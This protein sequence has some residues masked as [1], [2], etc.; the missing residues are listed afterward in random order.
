MMA[1]PRL[2]IGAT[3]SGSG[4]TMITCGILQALVN[5]GLKVASFKCGPDYI[6]PMFHREVIGTHS[7]NLDT[8]FSG[9]NDTK[10]LLEKNATGMDISI[11]EGVMG[12]YDGVGGTTP[13]AGAYDL[14]RVTDTPAVLIVNTKGMS[15]SVLP[16]IKGFLEYKQD[17]KIKGV[18][19]NQ[20]SEMIYPLLKAQAEDELGIKVYGYVPRITDFTIESRHLGLVMPD[21]VE[22]LSVKLNGLAGILEKTLEIDE[23]IAL[24]NSA[25]E[26]T[27]KKPEIPVLEE[28]DGHPRVAVARDNAFCFYYQDN[29]DLLKEMGAQIV[30][31]SPINDKHLPENIDGLI[32]GGGYPELFGKELSE[33]KTMLEDMKRA[34]TGGLP[35]LA[36]CGGFMYLHNKMEAMDGNHYEMVGAIDGEVYR[37]PKLSRF[38]YINITAKHD[39]LLGK[40]GTI[41]RAHEFHYFDSTACGESFSAKKPLRKRGWDCVNGTD[42]LE[43]GFPHMYYY[44]NPQA[45]FSFLKKCVAI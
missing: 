31:F 39:Q 21:E 1:I 16:L 27:Y 17:S 26:L 33:N 8:F 38:G 10:Y 20:M 24:A 45:V 11:M 14:A 29:L 13:I 22:E 42:T 25:P 37:T 2:L 4:K 18:I 6:D 12:Y 7:R 19:F 41:L 36:E 9:E 30:E 34:I 32:L 15:L 43:A 35:T 3:A 5:R 44:S 23:L 28:R 40:E